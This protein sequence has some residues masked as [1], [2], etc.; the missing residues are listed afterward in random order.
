MDS[1]IATD[2]NPRRFGKGLRHSK[3]GLWRDRVREYHLRIT[4]PEGELSGLPLAS[5]RK[6]EQVLRGKRVSI[7][8]VLE[9]LGRR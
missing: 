1:R 6:R 8:A 7:L 9:A 5:V 3:R 2:D 4:P